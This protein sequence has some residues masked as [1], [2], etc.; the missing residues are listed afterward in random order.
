MRGQAI[1]A[2]GAHRA[3]AHAEPLRKRAMIAEESLDIRARAVLALAEMCD[4]GSLDLWTKLSVVHPADLAE[5]L[6]PLLAKNAPPGLNEM[7]KSALKA[8]GACR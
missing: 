6:A 1:D 8:E 2:L 7:A 4:K 3:T 5:R